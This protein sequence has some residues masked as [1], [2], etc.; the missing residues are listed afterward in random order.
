MFV[1]GCAREEINN[2]GDRSTEF[3][4]GLSLGVAIHVIA[5]YC[6]VCPPEP[7]TYRVTIQQL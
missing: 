5:I 1:A 7:V 2:T 6:V 3:E 4:L